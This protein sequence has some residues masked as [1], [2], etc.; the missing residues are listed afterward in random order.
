[1]RCCEVRAASESAD[2]ISFRAS[3]NHS[4]IVYFTATEG[5]MTEF[6]G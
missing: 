3:E 2:E 1:M 4:E 6:L 5:E